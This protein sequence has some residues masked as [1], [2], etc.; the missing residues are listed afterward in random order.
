MWYCIHPSRNSIF[1]GRY[2]YSNLVD[3]SERTKQLNV[4]GGGNEVT[5]LIG[6][7]T[8]EWGIAQAAWPTDNH[9][10]HAACQKIMPKC[11]GFEFGVINHNQSKY[12]RILNV[13]YYGIWTYVIT[14]YI[15][16]VYYYGKFSSKKKRLK[17][18]KQEPDWFGDHEVTVCT[19]RYFN[20]VSKLSYELTAFILFYHL[21]GM[22]SDAMKFNKR[23][24]L[25]IF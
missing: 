23:L 20:T 1:P 17:A 18:L 24:K 14:K 2:E 7:A 11:M 5:A 25:K 13:Y 21:S 12:S 4:K 6:K 8:N 22:F 3:L 10:T 16:H 15:I 9:F 19:E